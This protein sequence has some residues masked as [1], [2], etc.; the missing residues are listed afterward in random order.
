MR[1]FIAA[2]G[3]L[4]SGGPELLH[5][6]CHELRKLGYEAK[7]L[8]YYMEEAQETNPVHPN[9]EMYHNSYVLETD[10]V[11]CEDACLIVPEPVSLLILGQMK[12]CKK[13]IWW[14]SVD[15]FYEY[16][17]LRDGMRLKDMDIVH[18][19]QCKYAESIL[20][21][22]FGIANT[23][24]RYLSD[25]LRPEFIEQ[26]KN[27]IPT[28][29]KRNIVVYNPKKGLDI[30]AHL[31]QKAGPSISFVPLV[32]MTPAQVGQTL[33]QAKVYIDFGNH[34]GKDRIPREAAYSGCCVITGTKGS[35]AYPEDVPIPQEY[36]FK[37][38]IAQAEEILNLIRAIF[39]DYE[40]YRKDFAA[41]CN[42]IEGEKKKFELDTKTVFKEIESGGF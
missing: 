26:V 1:Y 24:I 28:G 4:A 23:R 22:V 18:L 38:G 29:D 31:M 16:N 33:R 7:M 37:D 13:I 9:Y 5:Q 41:Y 3:G 8:Y 20:V 32:H 27:S 42:R 35:A 21:N 40:R 2:P 12:R 11:D 30:T 6:L 14:L 17:T 10:C 25:Y 34:P 39:A 19:V 15:F 36:K